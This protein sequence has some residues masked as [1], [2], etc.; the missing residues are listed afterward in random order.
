[1]RDTGN[2]IGRHDGEYLTPGAGGSDRAGRHYQ[3]RRLAPSE[4]NSPARLA[5]LSVTR[6]QP[7]HAA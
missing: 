7:R 6:H 3:P 4:V 1:M 2:Y 5:E